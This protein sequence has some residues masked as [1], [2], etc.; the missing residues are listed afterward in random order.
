M[1][2]YDFAYKLDHETVPEVLQHIHYGF[3]SYEKDDAFIRD[4]LQEK[5]AGAGSNLRL[6]IATLGSEGSL[7][8]DGSFYRHEI[9]PIKPVDTMGAGD[10]FIAGFLYGISRGLDYRDAMKAG[11]DK[12]RETILVKGAF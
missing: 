11:S 6:L 3:F 10:S 7:A 8:Y 9:E 5:W 1:I 12:A 4:Y 2:G